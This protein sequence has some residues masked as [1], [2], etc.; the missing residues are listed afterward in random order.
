MNILQKLIKADP[1]RKTRFHDLRGNFVGWLQLGAMPYWTWNWVRAKCG[2]YPRL[3]W[4]PPAARQK[5]QEIAQPS[6]T[7]LECGSGMSSL[8]WTSRV[9]KVVA[10]ETNADWHAKLSKQVSAEGL[11]N[12]ELHRV[13]DYSELLSQN[14]RRADLIVIDGYQ[15]DVCAQVA[16]A[17]V[18]KPTWIYLDN[19]DF[20]AIQ[21]EMQSAEATLLGLGE[22]VLHR[23]YFRGV[24]PGVLAPT[25]SLLVRIAPAQR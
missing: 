11:E 14:A 19:S 23:E 4:I 16:V 2:S 5:L 7:V 13:E 10:L 1:T 3:P 25:Q 20:A 21:A 9:G 6:W 17:A 15:R 8:W 22:R 24:P 12:L 18:T